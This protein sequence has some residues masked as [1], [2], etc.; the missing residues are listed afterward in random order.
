MAVTAILY[1]LHWAWF[2]KFFWRVLKPIVA[3]IAFLFVVNWA[4]RMGE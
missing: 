2:Q 4:R 3:A 1:R